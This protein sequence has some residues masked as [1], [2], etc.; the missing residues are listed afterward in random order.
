MKEFN[1]EAAM[2]CAENT[3]NETAEVLTEACEEI[4]RLRAEIER[5]KAERD[6][7]ENEA[8]WC[9]ALIDRL[10]Q[11][12]R[13][14]G[15]A[16]QADRPEEVHQLID[17]LHFKMS[18]T[19]AACEELK[20]ENAEL[21]KRLEPGGEYEE[22]LG[23]H[24]VECI[25]HNDKEREIER[26]R[27]IDH[28]AA[29]RAK[30]AEAEKRLKPSED[31]S[32]LVDEYS[33]LATGNGLINGMQGFTVPEVRLQEWREKK[34]KILDHENALR[35]RLSEAEQAGRALIGREVEGA[36]KTT[37]HHHG[38]INIDGISSAA[39]RIKGQMMVIVGALK[40]D[41]DK[42]RHKLAESEKAR[43]RLERAY[44]VLK[45][46]LDQ[47]IM[48]NYNVLASD[49]RAAKQAWDEADAILNEREESHD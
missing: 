6:K 29:L 21:K 4:G 34:Q 23:R 3:M 40:R 43:K 46:F 47:G 48:G 31:F 41:R 8:D 35:L 10:N 7:L 28:E 16:F 22:L 33:D 49:C 2:R 36:L 37:I 13:E 5:L 42:L 30:L 1:L 26:Q 25:N 18:G 39:K 20:A 27:L 15:V 24:A 9:A 11:W 44:G 12:G 14:C 45:K 38:P 17:G 32:R 19:N